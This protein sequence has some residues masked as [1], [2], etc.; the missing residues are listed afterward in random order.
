MVVGASLPDIRGFV[1]LLGP[2]RGV[3]EVEKKNT[4]VFFK[5]RLNGCRK[6][7]LLADGSI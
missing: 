7:P 4:E 2:E 6:L 1:V 3:P 5:T